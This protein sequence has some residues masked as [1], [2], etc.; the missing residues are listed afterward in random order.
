MTRDGSFPAWR[1][2]VEAAA[3]GDD[4]A[5]RGHVCGFCGGDHPGASC[6][7]NDPRTAGAALAL[8]DVAVHRTS[9][10]RERLAV[11]ELLGEKE[12]IRTYAFTDESLDGLLYYLRDT[13]RELR[14]AGY[15]SSSRDA[16]AIVASTQT[17]DEKPTAMQLIRDSFERHERFETPE[18][19]HGGLM[20]DG[21]G[22]YPSEKLPPGIVIVFAVDATAD[23]PSGVTKPFVV[24]DRDG[25]KVLNVE[26]VG[27]A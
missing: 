15:L 21:V 27:E 2:F 11:E 7:K 26:Y 20:V 4:T 1:L 6:P 3:R 12:N 19:P 25:V 18:T 14:E 16:G 13:V 8:R 22:V 10:Y 23:T 17:E 24:R 5:P 9:A